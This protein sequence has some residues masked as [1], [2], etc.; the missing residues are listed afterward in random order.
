MAGVPPTTDTERR[1][2]SRSGKVQLAVLGVNVAFWGAILGWTVVGDHPDRRPDELEDRRFAE[3]AQ[4]ICADAVADIAALDLDLIA[5]SGEERADS[6]DVTNE[7]L[8]E[9]VADLRG[10]HRPA[11]QEGEWVASW[12]DDWEVHIEDRQRWADR[13]RAGEDVPFSE[14]DRAGVQVSKIVDNFA[15]V[16]RMPSCATTHDV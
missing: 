10:L 4:P 12:L 13:Q 9:M 2:L 16:N 15:E 14:S 11:G 7:R 1:G 6:V 5:D 3:A 8:R